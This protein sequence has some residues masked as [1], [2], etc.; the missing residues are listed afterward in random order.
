[1]A[2]GEDYQAINQ[3]YRLPVSGGCM[4]VRGC[5]ADVVRRHWRIPFCFVRLRLI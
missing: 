1:M 5:V 2:A 4:G 3:K